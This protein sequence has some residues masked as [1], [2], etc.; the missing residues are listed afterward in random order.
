M[1]APSEYRIA[2]E[3]DDAD[4]ER[5]RDVA[6]A[7]ARAFVDKIS[8]ENAGREKRD[9]EVQILDLAPPPGAPVSPRPKRD[10]LGA[11]LLGAALGVVRRL[12]AGVP[13]LPPPASAPGGTRPG[14]RR[15]R[16]VTRRRGAGAGAW[17]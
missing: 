11:A 12:P 13:G 9:I 14:P 15:R 6:N 2:I 17:A 5:A 1:A 4:P 7:A 16:P 3:V 10:A 8:A